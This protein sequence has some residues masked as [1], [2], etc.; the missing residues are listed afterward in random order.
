MPGPTGALYYADTGRRVPVAF[1]PELRAPNRGDRREPARHS[2]PA[3]R[4]HRPSTA[5]RAAAAVRCSIS[6]QQVLPSFRPT[7]GM[8]R[9]R[10]F[11]VSITNMNI[12]G[13]RRYQMSARAE[14]AQATGERILDA[15]IELFWERPSDQIPLTAVAKRSGVTVQTII[16][17]FGNKEGLIAAASAR[18]AMRVA[19]S[20]SVATPGNLV[21]V[22]DNL[23]AHY[24]ELGDG[25]IRL[26]AEEAGSPA[27]ARLAQQ[28]RLVHRQWCERAF[29]PFLEPLPSAV[30]ARRLAQFVAV[31]DVYTW[32]LLRRDSG[33]SRRETA[34][35]TFE[36]LVALTKE[37]AQ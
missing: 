33:L 18:E 21:E 4:R 28:G 22:V 34:A 29:G 36:I 32:K 35:A 16:R 9:T 1:D 27:L 31:S 2:S 19:E 7:H 20:R 8:L 14:A 23:I 11:D 15:A 10:L 5:R 3:G 12:A 30:R 25:V 24:E 6:A 26:L 17:R 37:S 13:T